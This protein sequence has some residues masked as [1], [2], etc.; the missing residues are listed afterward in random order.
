MRW[1]EDNFQIIEAPASDVEKEKFTCAFI[2]KLIGGLLM[3]DKSRNLD[4]R[5][6][7]GQEIEEE[8]VWTSYVDPRIQECVSAEFFANRNIWYI[9]VPV[10]VFPTIEMHKSDHIMQQF[11]CTQ[12]I[13]LPPQELDDLHNIN[14][15]G[16]LKED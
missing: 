15:R 3:L 2:L 1:L 8:F 4:I 13:P 14:L 9:K 16:K 11:G 10:V 6:T 7:L 5:L 12:H